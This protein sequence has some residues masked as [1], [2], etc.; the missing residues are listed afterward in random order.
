MELH[1]EN[2]MHPVLSVAHEVALLYQNHYILLCSAID[3]ATFF[4]RSQAACRASIW[5]MM[6]F[7]PVLLHSHSG[8]SITTE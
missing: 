4:R 2:Y 1:K 7:N 5:R 6:S 8:T 3:D